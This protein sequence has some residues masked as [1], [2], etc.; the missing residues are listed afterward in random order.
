MTRLLSLA[1]RFLGNRAPKI[2]FSSPVQLHIGGHVPR[3]GWLIFDAKEGDHVDIVGNCNNLSMFP[4]ESCSDIYCSHVLEHLS[5]RD[6]L[7]HVLG[8]FQ[9]M[10]TKEGELRISVPDLD[11]LCRL[12]LDKDIS[13][14]ERLFIL[15]VIYGGQ[16]DSHDL[17]KNGFDLELLCAWMRDAGFSRLERVDLFGLFPDNSAATIKG[18]PLSINIIVAK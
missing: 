10:L 1:R 12:F 2:D 7:P 11:V 18:H 6:E 15:K 13:L 8:E 3:E 9:R 14:E 4:D 5:Y 16:I 17:H